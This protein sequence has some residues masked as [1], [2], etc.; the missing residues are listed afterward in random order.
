V[1]TPIAKPPPKM[2]ISE[3]AAVVDA[4]GLL[5]WLAHVGR[6]EGLTRVESTFVLHLAGQRGPVLTR[7]AKTR[8]DAFAQ[9]HRL[10]D[11][12]EDMAWYNGEV[13][14]VRVEQDAGG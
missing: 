3:R 9:A 2:R 1:T 13:V 10:M 5:T 8:A 7:R 6:M 14:G 4:S 12:A 11:E